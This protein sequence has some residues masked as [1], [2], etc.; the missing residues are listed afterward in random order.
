MSPGAAEECVA[1]VQQALAAIKLAQ[2]LPT[3]NGNGNAGNMIGFSK[4]H[5]RLAT[6]LD[7]QDTPPLL[8]LSFAVAAA[9]RGV[10]G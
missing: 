5:A 9:T 7:L 3:S 1:A 4:L 6:L 10:V 2:T 8:V